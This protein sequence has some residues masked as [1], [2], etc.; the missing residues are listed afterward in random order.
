[1]TAVSVPW[2]DVYTAPRSTGVAD[3]R[4]YLVAG[5]ALRVLLRAAPALAPILAS[6]RVR[7]A[8]SALMSGGEAGP[9]AALRASRRSAVYG[10]AVDAAGARASALQ[11]HPDPYGLTALAA[12]EIA[13]RALAG[14]APPGWQ[15]PATAYGPDLVLALPG[16]SREDL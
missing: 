9:S 13:A 6:A 12:V 5:T 15:T 8:V 1:M 10:E 2:A 4:T 7:D 3:V 14:D 11:R 16:V